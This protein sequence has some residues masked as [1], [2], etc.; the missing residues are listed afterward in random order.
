VEKASKHED[1]AFYLFSLV[2]SHFSLPALQSQNCNTTRENICCHV[3]SV[4]ARV[5]FFP[6]A[7]R[8]CSACLDKISNG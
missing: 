5:D 4:A 2:E 8:K 6:A 1:V 7:G 3:C